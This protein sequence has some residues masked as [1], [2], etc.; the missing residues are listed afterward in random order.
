MTR[1]IY[2]IVDRVTG[3]TVAVYFQFRGDQTDFDSPR[4]ARSSN[5]HG[6]YSD[7]K[8]FR[9]DEIEITEKV[10]KEGVDD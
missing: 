3:E 6:I 1:T 9:I 8:R 4:E 5:C 2:R 7:R 10:V